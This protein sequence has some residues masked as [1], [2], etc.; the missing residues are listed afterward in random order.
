MKMRKLRA[1]TKKIIIKT[2]NRQITSNSL[3]YNNQIKQIMK[4]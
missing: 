3:I 2:I 1:L 4:L